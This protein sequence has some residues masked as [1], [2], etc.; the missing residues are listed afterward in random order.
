MGAI[1]ALREAP[2][3]AW[4]EAQVGIGGPLV[5]AAAALLCEL[6]YLATG[7]PLFAALAY[8]GFLLNLF[9]LAPI[10]FLDGGRVATALS[11]WLWIVGLVALVAML[12]FDFNLIVLLVLLMSLPRV[13][14]LFRAKTDEERR[15]FEV[16]PARRL[17]MGALYF[18]LLA[19]CAAGMA[20]A[21]AQSGAAA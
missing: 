3:D 1:I 11:P 4:V 12:F 17:A 21:H 20:I 19:A 10:G 7:A 5:G 6:V 9:N 16:S 8:V 13:V 2:R 18:G 14:S 15:Y